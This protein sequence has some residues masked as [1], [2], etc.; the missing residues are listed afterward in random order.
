M[1]QFQLSYSRMPSCPKRTPTTTPE[2]AL[3]VL[4]IARS[5][6]GCGLSRQAEKSKAWQAGGPGP[7]HAPTCPD[8]PMGRGKVPRVQTSSAIC[9]MCRWFFIIP[10]HGFHYSRGTNS[11]NGFL[12]FSP[13]S[14]PQFAQ[15]EG[16]LLKSP[17]PRCFREAGT[18]KPRLRLQGEP[19]RKRPGRNRR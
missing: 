7:R 5:A 11:P 2:T 1:S 13:R 16:F 3:G 19:K 9:C 15:L 6:G 18:Q 12:F 17:G 8:G 10:T 4:D 14:H